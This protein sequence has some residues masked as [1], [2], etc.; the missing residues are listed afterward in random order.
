[1][2]AWGTGNFENDTALDW[3]WDLKTATNLKLIEQAVSDALGASDFLDA[4]LGCTCLAAAEVVAA[5][6]GN[7]G[8]GLPEDVS[9]WVKT[10]SYTHLRAHET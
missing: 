5:L 4:D 6:R 7:P 1:M 9:A 2:G 3:V 10:V 8:E